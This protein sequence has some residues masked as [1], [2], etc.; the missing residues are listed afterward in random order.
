MAGKK[1]KRSVLLQTRLS[2]TLH[3]IFLT[4]SVERQVL[5]I[6][7]KLHGNRSVSKKAFVSAPSKSELVKMEKRWHM[8]QEIKTAQARWL[9]NVILIGKLF[10]RA[11][12]CV[13]TRN[14]HIGKA[15]RMLYDGSFK[16][17]EQPIKSSQQGL[18]SFFIFHL[19]PG[20]LCC[21]HQFHTAIGQPPEKWL[22]RS[23]CLD[24][25]R[26][27]SSRTKQSGDS[28]LELW[29]QTVHLKFILWHNCTPH[30]H[31]VK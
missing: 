27:T 29:T 8:E 10:A 21:E 30:S 22:Q 17:L 6:I 3:H 2:S 19:C 18:V 24:M 25:F 23:C 16:I 20:Q 7:R 9:I 4:K 5:S 1:Q 11:D 28:Y 26:S 14:K 12:K 31:Y 13:K 15:M